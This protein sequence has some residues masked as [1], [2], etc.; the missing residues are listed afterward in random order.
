MGHGKMRQGFVDHLD[1]IQWE[2]TEE[3]LNSARALADVHL[4]NRFF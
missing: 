3:F 2:T 1:D 4:K